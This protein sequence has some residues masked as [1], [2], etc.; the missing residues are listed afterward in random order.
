MICVTS[1]V[2]LFIN[3]KTTWAIYPCLTTHRKTS[4]GNQHYND[5]IMNSLASKNHQHRGCLPN[6]L[7]THRWKKTPKPRVTGLCVGN[8]PV[9]GGFPA[10]RASNVE[11]VSIWWRVMNSSSVAIPQGAAKEYN[12]SFPTTLHFQCNKRPQSVNCVCLQCA[13]RL[14][15]LTPWEDSLSACKRGVSSSLP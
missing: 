2:Y 14:Y 5:V 13:V 8:S 9:T 12:V 4:L 10:Q 7:F 15:Q 11:N 6:R 3:S 1:R